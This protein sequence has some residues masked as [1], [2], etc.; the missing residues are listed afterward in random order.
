MSRIKDRG[1]TSNPN[2][3]GVSPFVCSTCFNVIMKQ[4]AEQVP[5]VPFYHVG[6]KIDDPEL[7]QKKSDYGGMEEI[8]K[9]ILVAVN[10]PPPARSVKQQSER[11]DKDSEMR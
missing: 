10:P 5:L 9:E 1:L 7:F 4:E 3:N 2:L 11:E 6:G 8:L